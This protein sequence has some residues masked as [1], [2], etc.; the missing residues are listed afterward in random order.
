MQIKSKMIVTNNQINNLSKNLNCQIDLVRFDKLLNKVKQNK[1]LWRRINYLSSYGDYFAVVHL[2]NNSVYALVL[3]ESIKPIKQMTSIINLVK[4][5]TPDLI[6]N[7]AK[8][9]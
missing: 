4:T 5:K 2:K 7:T 8:I 6:E 1:R 3:N 9:K